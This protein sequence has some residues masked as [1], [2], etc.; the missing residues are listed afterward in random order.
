MSDLSLPFERP[1]GFIEQTNFSKRAIISPDLDHNKCL[2]LPPSTAA[3]DSLSRESLFEKQQSFRRKQE[4]FQTKKNI[5]KEN[6]S[7]FCQEGKVKWTPESR[8]TIQKSQNENK[9]N[10]RI[11]TSQ[12][13]F[14]EAQQ[15]ICKRG[16][17]N[18]QRKPTS[19]KNF[20]GF[21]GNRD[22]VSVFHR[23]MPSKTSND[24]KMETNRYAMRTMGNDGSK[25]SS[26]GS[27][28][29]NDSSNF[30]SGFDLRH[31]ELSSIQKNPKALAYF[32]NPASHRG[33]DAS[34]QSVWGKQRESGL[35]ER[36][37]NAKMREMASPKKKPKTSKKSVEEIL[38]RLVRS[39]TK[40]N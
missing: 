2:P 5:Q 17:Q 28:S 10:G 1:S 36:E 11:L 23:L 14:N 37:K 34:I 31:S 19:E 22:S 33:L 24:P 9:L 30:S 3:D 32:G 26:V 35:R 12:A 29:L 18:N 16:T 40:K 27:F 4:D 7:H 15:A 38:R 13:C 39:P 8:K 25:Q 20:D 21:L 6:S